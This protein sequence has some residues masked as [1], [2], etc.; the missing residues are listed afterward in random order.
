MSED[1]WFSHMTLISKVSLVHIHGIHEKGS[2]DMSSQL[3]VSLYMY[4]GTLSIYL[5]FCTKTAEKTSPEPFS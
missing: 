5:S 4:S 1:G 2:G 3:F